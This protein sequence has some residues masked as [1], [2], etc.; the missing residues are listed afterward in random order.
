MF[1]IWQVQTRTTY[2]T[3][4]PAYIVDNATDVVETKICVTVEDE[5]RFLMYLAVDKKK[6][7][8]WI[9]QWF[10]PGFKP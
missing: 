10:L 6:I 4:S 7:Q 9:C 5:Y 2:T 8:G 3:I 1:V